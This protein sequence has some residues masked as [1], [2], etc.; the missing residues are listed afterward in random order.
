MKIEGNIS[1]IR[2]R[3]NR[4]IR[5]Y[6]AKIITSAEQYFVKLRILR[7]FLKLKLELDIELD[8]HSKF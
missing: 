6:I 3:L 1:S 7:I 8:L 4:K 2:S 5:D